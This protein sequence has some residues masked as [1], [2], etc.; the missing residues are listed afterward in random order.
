MVLELVASCVA[1]AE[2]LTVGFAGNLQKYAKFCSRC[3]NLISKIAKSPAE[4]MQI[5]LATALPAY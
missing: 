2:R 1:K 5:F 3:R 4:L